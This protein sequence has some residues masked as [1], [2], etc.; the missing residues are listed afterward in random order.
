MGSGV[1]NS[2]TKD[3]S[4]KR[5]REILNIY[6]TEITK[7]Y[8]AYIEAILV[9]GSLT[10]G[11]YV[12]GPGRDVDQITILKDE[13]GEAI[14]ERMFNI[15]TEI[16]KA[17]NNDIPI[18]RTVYFES[19]FGRPLKTNME[20]KVKNKHLIEIVTELKRMHESGIVLYG[21]NI[22]SELPIPT[23]EES[24]R[25]D[26]L[27]R[28]WDRQALKKNP[29]IEKT[30]KNLPIRI[31]VQIIITK[32]FKHYYYATGKTCSN[33]HE[34]ANKIAKEVPEYMFLDTL[35]LAAEF[36]INPNKEFSEDKVERLIKGCQ[37][38]LEWQGG[39]KVYEVPKINF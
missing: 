1:M 37:D 19:D 24:I 5:A 10:N 2:L 4:E 36:K 26:E 14:R 7:E 35:K 18:A 16:E 31:A 22:I 15:I 21:K 6:V 11:S 23:L 32:A 30:L 13:V 28:E 33:K 12:E 27:A 17:F 38:M 39:K 9:V 34:V 25:F 29:Q 20:L 3:Y 8:G